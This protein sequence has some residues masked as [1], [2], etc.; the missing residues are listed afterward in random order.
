MPVAAAAEAIATGGASA[1][2]G[3]KVKVLLECWSVSGEVRVSSGIS[4]VHIGICN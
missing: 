3:V 2:S 4:R 1:A